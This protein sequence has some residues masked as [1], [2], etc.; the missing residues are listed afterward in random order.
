VLIASLGRAIRLAQMMGLDRMDS[1]GAR[2]NGTLQFQQTLPP[3]QS[4]DELEQRRKTF[5]VLF[6]MDAYA[7]VR[8]GS[9][10][11]ID[12]SKVTTSLPT[13]PTATQ[14]ECVPM[15][16][17]GHASR[18][19]GTGEV[20]SFTGLVLMVQL[21]RRCLGHI[22]ASVESD[23]APSSVYSF[24][25]HHY[26]I[27]K[28][29]QSCSNTLLGKL[30]AQAL[31]DDDF[32]LALNLNLCAIDICLHE[33][34]ILRAQQDSLPLT[35]VME[36]KSRCYQAA[37]RIAEGI[38]LSQKLVQPK[39][40]LFKQ[41]NIYCMWPVCMAIQVLDR[42]LP[43]VSSSDCTQQTMGLL[44]LLVAGIRDMEDTSGHWLPSIEQIAKRVDEMDQCGNG[45][46]NAVAL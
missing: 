30:D 46:A 38:S 32:A 28:D 37:A 10:V 45:V 18:V 7:S 20:P 34:A 16:S 5:W 14:S 29:L 13:S 8:S 3:A 36:C 15:P 2:A 42:Q 33:A 41:M 35:L 22:R 17:L 39:R 19:Y 9:A 44:K 40:T 6:I 43:G 21:Y 4:E 31:L 26:T 27:D 24:W 12:G 25:E 11:A 1:T 23:L